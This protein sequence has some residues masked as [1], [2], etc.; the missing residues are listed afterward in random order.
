MLIGALEDTYEP[1][2]GNDRQLLA[3]YRLPTG[4]LTRNPPRHKIHISE[5][6]FHYTSSYLHTRTTSPKVTLRY[7]YVIK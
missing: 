2:Y 4:I 1:K 7:T 5:H 6:T 3:L